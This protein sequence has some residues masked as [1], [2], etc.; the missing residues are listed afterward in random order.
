MTVS[1]VIRPGD[2]VDIRLIQQIEREKIT[3][4]EAKVYKSQVL[5]FRNNGNLQIAMPTEA[6]RLVLLA[7]GVR[8]E[9]T[10]YSKALLYSFTGQVVERYKKD[11]MYILEI[12][13]KSPLEKFQRRE[14]YR[15][16][17][18]LETSFYLLTEEQAGLETVPA[19]L[20]SLR[21]NGLCESERTGVIVDLSGGGARMTT[22][23][24]V[25]PGS[26]ILLVLQLINE[27]VN[28]QYHIVTNVIS[29]RRLE[30]V[31]ERRFELRVKFKITDDKMREEIIRYI[32][33]EERRNRQ[34]A[35]R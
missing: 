4:E 25:E 31:S 32:F 2:K 22:T 23:D 29:C 34:K 6:G 8:F 5:D 14:Y 12:E 15:Y 11:N 17:C 20:E 3:G 16:E 18:M 21:Q 7:L 19:M 24:E 13:Q 9:F 26:S 10:F 27:K 28:K 33:E 30:N 35:S 1:D